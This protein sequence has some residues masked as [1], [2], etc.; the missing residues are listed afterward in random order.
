MQK[1]SPVMKLAPFTLAI[2]VLT[3][4]TG[5]TLADEP[6]YSTT[7]VKRTVVRT[8]PRQ[9]LLQP[10]CFE[11][12]NSVLLQCAPQTYVPLDEVVLNQLNTIPSR[13]VRPY[14]TLFSW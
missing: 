4:M 1:G 2:G 5:A 6:G 14:P 9:P 8:V 13:V 3:A 7:V 12:G 10:D 11:T